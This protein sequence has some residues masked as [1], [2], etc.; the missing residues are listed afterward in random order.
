MASFLLLPPSYV[1]RQNRPP[2][3]P[4]CRHLHYCGS[5]NAMPHHEGGECLVFSEGLWPPEEGQSPCMQHCQKQMG[6]RKGVQASMHGDGNCMH[7]CQV[8]FRT[9]HAACLPCVRHKKCMEENSLLLPYAQLLAKPQPEKATWPCSMG[10]AACSM[11]L[12][13]R[14]PAHLP[15]K[16]PCF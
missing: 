7:Q 12:P 2:W 8:K 4:L 5:S 9:G 14:V 13:L 15:P 11:P 10:E 1:T 3:S 6:R 16:V